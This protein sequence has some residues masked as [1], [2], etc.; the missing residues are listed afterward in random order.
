MGR[1]VNLR[2]PFD[3]WPC[4]RDVWRLL[5]C[6]LSYAEIARRRGTSE[7]TVRGHAHTLLAKLGVKNRVQAAR[8]AWQR[9]LVTVDEAWAVVEIQRRQR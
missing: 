7:R 4:E 6:G 5:A 8:L 3:P 1:Q 2:L 9:G